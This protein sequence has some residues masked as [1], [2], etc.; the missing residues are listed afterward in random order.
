ML[1]HSRRS[2]PAGGFQIDATEM[3]LPG[4]HHADES[5]QAGMSTCGSIR[6]CMSGHRRQYAGMTLFGR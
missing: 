2:P 6:A 1:A 3:M 4:N 5:E